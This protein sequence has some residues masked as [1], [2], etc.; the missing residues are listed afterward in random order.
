MSLE[1]H[2]TNPKDPESIYAYGW[3]E[4]DHCPEC[5]NIID[6]EDN[7]CPKC[8]A[9]LKEPEEASYEPK[10]PK[11]FLFFSLLVIGFLIGL[12]LWGELFIITGLIS[13]SI[14]FPILTFL[15]AIPSSLII[16]VL[17]YSVLTIIYSAI[18][19]LIKSIIKTHQTTQK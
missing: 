4:E 3:F 10:D 8:G 14:I 19:S 11:E 1:K 18:K 2:L 17:L 7:Y 6:P 15:L 16:A 5:G 12:L 9:R 13:T